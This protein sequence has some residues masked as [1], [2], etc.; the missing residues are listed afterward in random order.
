[1]LMTIPG[2]IFM[3]GNE[4]SIELFS[5]YARMWLLV[6]IITYIYFFIEINKLLKAFVKY[7]LLINV[8][9]LIQIISNVHEFGRIQNVFSHPNFY[10]F[11]LIIVV[12]AIIYFIKIKFIKFKTGLILILFNL[13]M[14][15]A[16][17]SKTAII[18]F[19]AAIIYIFYKYII[20]SNKYLRIPILIITILGVI[21]LIVIF[22]D[23]FSELRIFNLDYGLK[24]NQINSFEWRILNWKSKFSVWENSIFGIVFGYGWGSETLYGFKG[25]AMHNEY[26]RILFEYGIIGCICIFIFA[27][28]FFYNIMR[29]KSENLKSFYISFIIIIIVGAMAENIFVAVETLVLYIGIIFSSNSAEK[30]N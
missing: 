14:I 16:A 21:F 15:I 4:F 18:A 8:I 19:M 20:K 5:T 6:P 13:L 29:L 23:K 12:L 11:Y 27:K 10:A 22:K 2:A 3:L 7:S 9:G 25:F 1:M 24:E 26:L 28:R 17:G 30:I